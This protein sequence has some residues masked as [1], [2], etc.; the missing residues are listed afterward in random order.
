M[1]RGP[2]GCRRPWSIGGSNA[3]RLFGEPENGSELFGPEGT[4]WPWRNTWEPGL[5]KEMF[6]LV[7]VEPTVSVELTSPAAELCEW[8]VRGG[9]GVFG[10]SDGGK[11][12]GLGEAGGWVAVWDRAGVEAR[13]FGWWR[14]AVLCGC[15]ITK[16]A[17]GLAR[18]AGE[19]GLSS[20]ERS[21][22]RVS[23]SL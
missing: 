14:I 5:T 11:G 23:L 18:V 13:G 15:A 17:A 6:V 1:V 10:I 22:A 16:H 20:P 8:L 3:G 21:W 19:R 7:P 12:G 9:A 2:Q 4:G